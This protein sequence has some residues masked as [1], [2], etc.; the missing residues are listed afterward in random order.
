MKTLGSVRLKHSFHLSTV[1]KNATRVYYLHEWFTWCYTCSCFP[2]RF[3]AF[4]H[5]A[6]TKRG[7]F[8]H[9]L[10]LGKREKQQLNIA[11][12]IGTEYCFTL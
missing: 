2:F 12:N 6:G 10:L 7:A 1:K 4:A 5:F 8:A 3:F 11:L 9:L